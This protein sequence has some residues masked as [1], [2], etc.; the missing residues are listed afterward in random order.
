MTNPSMPVIPPVGGDPDDPAVT[1]Q[2]TDAQ[3]AQERETGL[4]G[5]DDDRPLDTDL[6]DDRLNSADADERAATEGT[7]ED[8]PDAHR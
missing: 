8:D 6:D 3:D 7:M 5:G 1:E 2:P 4:L